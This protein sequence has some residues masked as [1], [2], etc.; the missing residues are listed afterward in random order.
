MF[1]SNRL[2]TIAFLAALSVAGTFGAAN[3]AT[4]HGQPNCSLGTEPY[5]FGANDV[6]G[7]GSSGGA[8]WWRQISDCYASPADLVIAGSP[9]TYVDTTLFDYAGRSSQ[10]CA[11][12][13]INPGPTTWYISTGSG[14]GILGFF[15]HDPESFWGPVNEANGEIQYFPTVSYALSGAGL[16]RKI[17]DLYDQGT[18]GGNYCVSKG[19]CIAIAAPDQVSCTSGS[20]NPYPNPLYCYGPI[21]Q[22]PVSIDPIAVFYTHG[23]V[24]EKISGAGKKEIDY[25][26]N[27]QNGTKN[28]GLRLSVSSLCAIYNGQITNWNDSRLTTDNDGVSLEDTNDPT[29][30]ASWSVPLEAVGRGDASGAT[31]ALTRHLAKVCGDYSYNLYK[32]AT[33]TL[34]FK[35]V[36]C[37]KPGL[38]SIVVAAGSMGVATCVNFSESPEGEG[39][40]CSAGTK[41]PAGYTDCIQQARIGYIGADYVLP[42][43][44]RN[45]MN[46]YG[47]FSADVENVQGEFVAPSTNAASI[48]FEDAGLPPQTDAKGHYCRTCGTLKRKDPWDWNPQALLADPSKSGAYPIV[49][50]TNFLGYSCYASAGKVSNLVGQLNYVETA[51]INTVGKG[52]LDSSG[53]AA[54]PKVW[55]KAIEQT[56]VSNGDALGLQMTTV[57]GS[58][59]C[60]ASGIIGA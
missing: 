1:S 5:T 19:A 15:G 22:F 14:S 8:P 30:A 52:I 38:G 53:V 27:V 60:S 4:C 40:K 46:S 20:T 25:G 57:G 26:L 36:P 13:Q 32:R 51:P 56:F 54:L 31:L 35:G 24:Y 55:R 59:I 43:V 49:G 3:G 10:D 7:G 9:P 21:V 34:P 42:Y 17:V 12:T 44:S 45:G 2:L 37:A 47:L 58:T 16:T 28:G 50:T 18:D 29:P 33:M 41:L 23:G 6:F 11:T 39:N 48:A